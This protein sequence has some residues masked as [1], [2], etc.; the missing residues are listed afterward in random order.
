MS[1]FIQGNVALQEIAKA[2][3]AI[4]YREDLDLLRRNY[5][6]TNTVVRHQEV[7]T[8]DLA[9]FAQSPPTYRNVCIGVVVSNGFSGAEL[10]AQ[11]RTLGA[12]LMFEINGTVINRWKVTASGEPE[13]KEG[14]PFGN[15][16]NAFDQ[17]RK[18][19][20]PESILRAK[21]IGDVKG[22]VQLDFY[23]E[24]YMPF[25]ENSNFSKLEYLLHKILTEIDQVYKG[26]GQKTPRFQNL[27]RLTFR[28]IAAKVFRDR[29]HPGGW[30]SDD[31]LTAIRAIEAYYGDALPPSSLHKT[32]VLNA[33][34]SIFLSTFNYPGL[35]EDDLALFFEKGFITPDTREELGIHSTPPRVVDY[36]VHKLPFEDLPENDRYVVE[37]FAGHGRFLVASMRRMRDLLSTP[38]SDAERH[39]YFV[40]RLSGIELDEMSTEVCR[41]SLML[42]DYPNRNSWRI[43]AE[44]VFA[45]DTL[46]RELRRARILLSNPPFEDIP[47]KDRKRYNDPNILIQKPAELLRN[48]ML[49]PPEL[50]G[51]VLPR[52]FESGR[53]YSR[54]HRKLAET[55]SN[56]E[57]VALPEVFNYSDAVTTLVM[58]HGKRQHHSQAVV[59]CREVEEGEKREDFLLRGVEPPAVEASIGVAEYLRPQFSLWIPRLSRIWN[60]LAKLPKIGTEIEVHRGLMWISS[61]GKSD[62]SPEDFISDHE[63]RGYMKGFDKAQGHLLQYALQGAPLYLS[64]RPEDQYDYAYEHAWDKPKVICNAIRLSRGPWRLGAVADPIGMAFSQSFLAI[65]P[66]GRASIFA[67][68]ALFNSPIANGYFYAKDTGKHNRNKTLKSL[69][70]SPALHLESGGTIDSLSREMH[71]LIQRRRADEAKTI[72][73][74]LE[75]EI[76]RAYDLPPV[77]ERELLDTFQGKERPVPFEFSGYYPEGLDA[78]I[79]L[80]ELISPAFVQARA[81]RILERLV[82]VNDPVISEAMALLR[83]ELIDDE[84]L[85][86]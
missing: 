40:R 13:F 60:Y 16:A 82:P 64:L 48:V 52:T 43:Y 63:K 67:L 7:H 31:A 27:F 18:E 26:L 29:K 73:M 23:D 81:D 1:L 83:E 51:L 47:P 80:H 45:T 28:F 38:M 77:L 44:N 37:P 8:I 69:P 78:Y 41:L 79:P 9:G 14:I 56:I 62:K 70:L 20:E 6:Y 85:P 54:F 15:I 4:G 12:P 42:A 49:N 84:G 61:S 59:T 3:Q 34:W 35:S 2:M 11:H 65:W 17:R 71:R 22:P 5:A 46:Q 72:L 10:V 66:K 75:A 55:Y 32:Q 53:S 19:W 21:A 36:I 25:L 76:L 58:A 30:Q 74:Q 86:S 50:L 33:I 57:L 39:N 24:D 68:A